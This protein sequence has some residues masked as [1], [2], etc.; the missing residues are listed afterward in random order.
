MLL[1]L[2]HLKG[3]TYSPSSSA[4]NKWIAV[5]ADREATLSVDEPHYPRSIKSLSQ[6]DS[7][8][9]IVPTRHI[10]TRHTIHPINGV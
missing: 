10:V 3:W 7:F 9:L 5:N 2:A 8:L 1:M 4:S 6:L